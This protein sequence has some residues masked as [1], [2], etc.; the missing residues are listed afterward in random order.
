MKKRRILIVEDDP[1]IR[2]LVRQNITNEGWQVSEASDGRS[3]LEQIRKSRPDLIVLDLMLPEMSGKEVC[4]MAKTDPE[5]KSIPI[6]IVTAKGEEV[7]RIIGF[8]LGADDYVAK[9][10]SP[11]ELVLRI[12]AIFKRM[13]QKLED[14]CE[15]GF[16]GNQLEV[17]FE[18]RLVRYRGKT[19]I[20]TKV[21]FDLLRTLLKRPGWVFSRDDLMSLVLGIDAEIESRTIDMHISRLREKLGGF[22]KFIE[23]LRGVGYRLTE[24]AAQK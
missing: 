12:R 1:D 3:A 11:R 19:V 18:K 8:E 10:F 17:D 9:P 2:E 4:R 21:E 24:E 5:T 14:T 7:D 13:E 15:R 20:L 16:R 22:G 23:T 6:I